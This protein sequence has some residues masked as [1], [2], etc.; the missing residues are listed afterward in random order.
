M[1]FWCAML[2]EKP[3]LWREPEAGEVIGLAVPRFPA[4][5]LEPV[6]LGATT[7]VWDTDTH[8]LFD[9]PFLVLVLVFGIVFNYIIHFS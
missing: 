7:E 8:S 5:V 9:I 1:A 6:V 3:R 4:L 2:A